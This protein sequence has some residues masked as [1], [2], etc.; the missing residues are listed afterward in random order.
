VYSTSSVRFGR[1][2]ERKIF[3][4]LMISP[5]EVKGDAGCDEFVT[6]RN[7]NGPSDSDRH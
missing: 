7:E 3:P 1:R 4:A 2:P 6:E 5:M